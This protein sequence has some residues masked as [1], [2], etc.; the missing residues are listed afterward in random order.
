MSVS[1]A[2]AELGL[3]TVPGQSLEAQSALLRYALILF[4]VGLPIFAWTMSYAADRP[5]ILAS[6]AIFAINWAA[7]YVVVDATR[8]R[9]ALR[10]DIATRTRL[11]ILGGLLWAAATAQ[12]TILALH[13]GSA[14]EPMLFLALGVAAICVFF[15]AP[16]L[17][18]LLIVA[19]AACAAP[20]IGVYLDPVTRPLGRTALSAVC[21]ALAISLIFN[22]LL[23]RLFAMAIERED[24][25]DARAAALKSAERL[26]KSKSNLIATLSQEVRNGLSGVAH[27]LASASGAN[28]R[29]QP[30]REQLSAALGSAEDL[31]AVL[32]ATLDTETA[33]AGKLTLVRRPFDPA[34][35]AREL[36]AL[37]R[38]QAAAKGLEL[39]I[40]VDEGLAEGGSVVGDIVRTRQILGN[41]VGNAIKYTVRGR[42]EV[43]VERLGTDR[44]RM[45]VADTGPGLSADELTDAFEA[46]QR[47]ERTCTG[48]P[49]A[50]LGLSLARELALLMG[51]EVAAESALGVG[52]CFKLDMPFDR[53]AQSPEATEALQP[54][55]L[56]SAARG[57][58]VLIAEDDALSAA[59][60]R[61][62]LEQL[63]HHVVHAHDGR[64]A[65]DLAE[66]CEVDLYIIADRLAQKDGAATTRAIRALKGQGPTTPII[67]LIA[68]D[69]EEAQA[70]RQAGV[71]LL[72]RKPVTVAS[73]A[74]A[75]TATRRPP[76]PLIAA[77]A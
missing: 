31:I 11:H 71:D 46:F 62:V 69:A 3:K 14:A 53:D 39:S 13:A 27:V 66:I 26:A 74:R 59:M 41:L 38:P 15:S 1:E 9:P 35:L 34:K 8:R 6:F 67:A 45:E 47:V 43:R 36:V 51:G 50:G 72:L 19:P 44:V 5:W 16:S 37:H 40:H 33:E 25:I 28:G 54:G 2:P 61:G 60:L 76:A 55:M 30:T 21:L 20:V 22:R 52:S 32:D 42:I 29:A 24:L 64:R 70:M 17:P 7:F 57:L 18:A 10:A 63:G 73:V 23:R 49:G 77:V 58:R 12:I 56:A 75:L 4:G 68:G 48:V 65:C